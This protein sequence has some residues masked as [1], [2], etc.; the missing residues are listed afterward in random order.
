MTTLQKGKLGETY[1]VG[2]NNEKQN[3]EIVTRVCDLLDEKVG[4]LPS[5][6]VRQKLIRYVKDRPGHD[7]R[8]A[9][10]ASKIKDELG[11]EPSV[12]F[13]EGIQLTVD[14]YLENPEWISSVL[15]GSYQEYYES[16]YGNR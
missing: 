5:G 13:E 12:T 15:D 8:Y 3:I 6:E 7:K 10:D 2:G 14:W 1:N 16:M 9:I 4:L 11:W